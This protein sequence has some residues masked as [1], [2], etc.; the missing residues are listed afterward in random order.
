MAQQAAR[1]LELDYY[2]RSFN[3]QVMAHEIFGYKDAHGNYHSSDFQRAYS[4]GGVYVADEFDNA[5]P[6]LATGINQALAGDRATFA[7]AIVERHADFRFV[8][9]GNTIGTGANASHVGTNRLNMATLDRL[10]RIPI[11]PD[12]RMELDIVQAASGNLDEDLVQAIVTSVQ[13]A[14]S[15]ALESRIPDSGCGTR[16]MLDVV[17]M[18]QTG[19]WELPDAIR[20]K[21]TMTEQHLARTFQGTPIGKDLH[22][23]MS[24]DDL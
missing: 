16:M 19:A 13:S 5:S 24:G 1:V 23:Q 11:D 3:G 15:V 10:I 12:L 6:N 2:V 22:L 8:A 17:K 7:D 21:T 18:L 9:C 20:A 4:N 14:R